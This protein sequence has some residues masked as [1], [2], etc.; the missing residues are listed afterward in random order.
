MTNTNTFM[1]NKTLKLLMEDLEKVEQEAT[2]I[3]NQINNVLNL[4]ND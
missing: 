1:K 3:R 4:K 2:K